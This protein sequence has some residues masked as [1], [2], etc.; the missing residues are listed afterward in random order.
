MSSTSSQ[1]N[2][3]ITPNNLRGK[4]K[5]AFNELGDSVKKQNLID[6]LNYLAN[7]YEGDKD[8]K[9]SKNDLKNYADCNNDDARNAFIIGYKIGSEKKVGHNCTCGLFS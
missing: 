8:I 7:H 6:G 2:N 3:P 4:Q 1:E 5:Q 9:F